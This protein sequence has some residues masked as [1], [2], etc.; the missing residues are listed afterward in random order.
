MHA[1]IAVAL[2][3]DRYL[4]SSSPCRRTLEECYHLSQS[5]V[6]F[7]RQL[8]EPI[9]TKDKDPI[10]GTAAALALLT[11]SCPDACT[12][13]ESWPLKPT[14]PSD[15]EWLRIG[16]GKMSLWPIA[17]PLRPDSLFC[18]LEPIYTQLRSPLPGK[19]I[20]GIPRALVTICHLQDTSTTETNPYFNAAHALSRLQ[21]L[22]DKQVTIGHTELFTRAIHGRFKSLLREK[23]PVALIL[24]YLWYGKAGRSIWWIEL[25]ARVERPSI[26]SYLRLYHK[27][28]IAIQA[29][30]PGGPL[31]DRWN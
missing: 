15:L 1:S 29:F 19:G 30:L 10:W 5:T 14:D 18:V 31:A 16:E 20:D 24:I 13:E 8:R 4:N 12:P 11:F 27:E 2:A 25:R 7:N 23:D 9:E 21:D 22:T 3:Y 28:N 17:D 26:C 6:L